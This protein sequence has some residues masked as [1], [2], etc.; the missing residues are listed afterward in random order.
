MAF[1]KRGNVSIYY[2]EHG[3]GF[4]VLLLPP[5]GMH[6]TVAWWDRAAFNPIHVLADT[7]H[8]VALDQRNAGSSAG[9]LAAGDPW[10]AYASDQ[11][12]L[13]DHL[14]IDRFHVLGCC[15]GCSYA[16]RLI[17]QA[18]GRIV[19][20]VL[21]QPVGIDEANRQTLPNGWVQWAQELVEKRADVDLASAEAFGKRMWAGDFVLSVSREFVKS[22]QTPMLVLAGNDLAHPRAIGLEVAELAPKA[23]LVVDWKEPPELI[24]GTIDRIRSFLKAHRPG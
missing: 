22:C 3:E 6:A 14:G 9:P 17:Q 2:E 1:C 15:I 13:M 24:P 10:E 16:L 7:F 12:G 23:E 21:E 8:L 11:L 20:A 18:P 4:P 5:G 19:S